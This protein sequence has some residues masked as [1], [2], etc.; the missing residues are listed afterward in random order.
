MDRK[1]DFLKAYEKPISSKKIPRS[2]LV[3]GVIGIIFYIVLIVA[4]FSFWLFLRKEYGEISH[5]VEE[6]KSQ[7]S[8]MRKRES[9]Y[10]LL[11]QQLNA[12]VKIRSEGEKDFLQA[13]PFF[14]K[15]QGGE[16]NFDKISASAKE[17]IKLSG[18]AT[19]ASTLANFLSLIVSSESS[20]LF[21]KI[22]LDSLTRDKDGSY[23]FSFSFAY[24]GI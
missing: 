16:I 20:N 19:N 5:Q 4:I 12:L 18:R 17:G 11:K 7:I 9:L 14:L 23:S 24:G 2:L 6:K 3:G 15:F 21:S 13:F 1:I 8:Q 22:I 10:I